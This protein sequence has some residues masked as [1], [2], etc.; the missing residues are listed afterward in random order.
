MLMRVLVFLDER[1]GFERWAR[2]PS[3]SSNRSSAWRASAV[4]ANAEDTLWAS[5]PH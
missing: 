1:D 4:A 2:F 3:C 5:S